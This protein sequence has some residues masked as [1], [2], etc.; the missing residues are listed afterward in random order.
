MATPRLMLPDLLLRATSALVLLFGG[1][2]VCPPGALAEHVKELHQSLTLGP[3]GR[4]VVD[5]TVA[6]D[7]GK[8]GSTSFCRRIVNLYKRSG[9]LCS[10]GIFVKGVT[11]G[12][13][14]EVEYKTR[15]ADGYEYVIIG[16]GRTPLVGQH[17]FKINYDVIH[18][19]NF[20][21]GQPELFYSVLGREWTGP[22]DKV[23]VSMTLAPAQA[24]L[25][26]KAV[27]YVGNFGSKKHARLKHDRSGNVITVE[28][29]KFVPG[30]DLL[31]V[32]PLPA[33]S[34]E[35]GALPD[36]LTEIY[37]TSKLAVLLP[38]GTLAVLFLLWLLIGSDQRF[39]KAPSFT[40][41]APW[42]PPSELTPAELGAV[43]DES[44]EDK[45]VATTIFDLACRGYLAIRELPNHGL[46]GYGTIDYEF[47]QP[48]QPVQGILKAHEEFF[49]NIIFTGR[50]KV[51]LSDMHGY[52]LDYMPVLRKQILQ[53]LTKDKYF[54]R[55]PQADRD[56][57]ATTAACV[58]AFGAALFAYSTFIDDSYKIGSYGILISGLLIFAGSGVMP[59]RTRK[60]VAA[61]EQGHTFE[62]FIMHGSDDDMAAAL[63]KDPTVFYRLLPYTL[64]L[65]GA[66]FWAHRFKKLV[67]QPPAWYTTLGQTD[68]SESFD[69]ELFVRHLLNAMKA[70]ETVC[71]MKPERK[72]SDNHISRASSRNLP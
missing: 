29:E 57:F 58:L 62:H 37:E 10:L 11:D 72:I 27:G 35:K 38:L 23:K 63:E 47:S 51:Y 26:G 49:L 2:F 33:G 21:S 24:A 71:A 44:C 31:L 55:N 59:K 30:Q 16:D 18:S 22:L 69:T 5:E 20:V 52:L 36:A 54:A 67:S 4:L 40:L 34:I 48:P 28:G 64:A 32:L 41:G 42:Q 60:G 45:D 68:G 25:A 8:A 46:T 43:M 65:G 50:N 7:F 66:E 53:G 12:W 56:Y 17:V 13:G 19:V 6:V 70:I 39:G 15:S 61:I 3:S 9:K 1:L 14:K